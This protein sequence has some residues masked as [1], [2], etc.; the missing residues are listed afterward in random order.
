MFG[1]VKSFH[2][3]LR[4]HRNE[5]DLLANALLNYETLDVDD[6]KGIIDSKSLQKKSNNQVRSRGNLQIDQDPKKTV[7]NGSEVFVQ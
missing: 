3:C 5:L 4:S 7:P 1:H 6:V 2:L